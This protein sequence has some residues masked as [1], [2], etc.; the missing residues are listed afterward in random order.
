MSSTLNGDR[1]GRSGTRT[2]LGLATAVMTAVAVPAA[3]GPGPA[4]AASVS[5]TLH[6]TCSALVISV[7]ADI[8]VTAD[9]P[10]SMEVGRPSPRFTVRG[11]AWVDESFTQYAYA[12]GAT[13]VDGSILAH[14][15]VVAP[16]GTIPQDVPLSIVR[17]AIPA[18]G[19]FSLTAT[20]T[21]PSVTLSRPGPGKIT[22]EGFTVRVTPRN[23]SGAP[24]WVGPIGGD[25]SLNP[26][27]DNAL[28][29]LDVTA[30][31]PPPPPAP[32]PTDNGNPAPPTARPSGTNT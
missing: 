17:T 4:A 32:K 27:Q 14:G 1:A 23:A 9:V 10:A 19:S 13:S 6:Y 18:S 16:E 30:P 11:T 7:P 3:F 29:A 28:Q 20:G 24:T 5:R 21:A 12:L 8:T 25:C 26:G 31:P 15:T 22:I 2:V